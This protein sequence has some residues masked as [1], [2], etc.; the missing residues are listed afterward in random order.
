MYR[1]SEE[2]AYLT[3]IDL[4]INETQGA[5][6]KLREE[7]K[8]FVGDDKVLA[9]KID[10]IQTTMAGLMLMQKHREGV[11]AALDKHEDLTG[12]EQLNDPDFS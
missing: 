9:S 3:L 4:H 7:L 10:F 8:T 5:L 6:I 12:G 1:R 11:K 2:K